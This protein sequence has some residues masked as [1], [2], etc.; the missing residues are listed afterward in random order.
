MTDEEEMKLKMR[1]A[2]LTE[3]IE[4]MHCWI[5]R[6]KVNLEKLDGVIEY[7]NGKYIKTVEK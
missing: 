2:R 7:I 6:I 3:E 1:N 4:A 5:G